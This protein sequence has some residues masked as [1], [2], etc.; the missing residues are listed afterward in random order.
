MFLWFTGISAYILLS[1][2]SCPYARS[3]QFINKT[4]G[5]H[6]APV[7]HRTS[8]LPGELQTSHSMC[9]QQYQAIVIQIADHIS[10]DSK[11]QIRCTG[12]NNINI[13]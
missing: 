7:T 6:S 12:M 1:G 8:I 9:L 11:V 5:Q 13:Q 10:T 4:P 2:M 3:I